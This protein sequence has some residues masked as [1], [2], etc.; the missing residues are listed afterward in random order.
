MHENRQ[1]VWR[2]PPR[3]AL[4]R[5]LSLDVRIVAA[6]HRNLQEMVAAGTFR[7]DLWY[8]ISVFPIHLPPLRDRVGDI[9]TLAAHFA[10]RAG[11]RLGGTPLSPSAADVALLAS[12]SWPG[13]VRELA[14]VIER[15]AILGNGR[16]L[17]VAAALGSPTAS[18][19]P[20]GREYPRDRAPSAPGPIARLDYVMVQHIEA[21][22]AATRGRIE[23]PY[24]AAARL[25]INPH[26]LRARMR[27]LGIEWRRFRT[28][29]PA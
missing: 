1:F 15:A 20:A 18:A 24:G 3:G 13:N 23:G 7:E 16:E 12:Y 19:A 4:H 21:A 25:G 9:P 8:R 2:A 26:T 28:R 27:K 22:L 17:K 10:W 6:T 29:P 11:K 5:S 14:S